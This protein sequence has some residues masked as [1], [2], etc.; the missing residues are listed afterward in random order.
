MTSVVRPFIRL[1]RA[2][3][4]RRSDSGSRAEVASSRIRIGGSL[5]SARAMAMRWRWP[6]ESRLPRS[7]ICGVVAAREVEDEVVG[8][9]GAGGGLDPR[10]VHVL[11]AVGDVGAH[12]VV[13][14]HRLLGDEADLLAQALERRVAHVD[15]VDGDGALG[16][17][18]E[19]RQ[20]LDERGLARARHA[21]DGHHLPGARG[22]GDPA[23]HGG[24]GVREAEGRRPCTRPRAACAGAGC[25]L[26]RSWISKWVSRTS[27]MRLLAASAPCRVAFMRDSRLIGV[28]MAK[29]A[30]RNEV[31]APVVRRP[32][33]MACAAVEER[34]D[35]GHAAHRLHE[36]GEDGGGARDPHV[37]VEQ[38]RRG[39]PEARG[40]EALHPER[41][42]HAEAGD[43][44][45]QDLRDV[46][47]AAQRR[48]VGGAQVAA[49]A[50][51]RDR[52]PAGMMKERAEGE[53]PVL[54]EQ[55]PQQ[56][57]DGQPFL[58]EVA[59]ELRHRGLDLLHVRRDV[60]HQRAVLWP[61]RNAKDWFRMW[62]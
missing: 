19:A 62:L 54:P 22:E 60:A 32:D 52:T 16:H 35:H 47:P 15:A 38:P 24:V 55:D 18:V 44:L 50:D 53:P 13:E 49:V 3:C 34:A 40:L 1:P 33:R 61:H 39:A 45:L 5:S 17:V 10:L 46:P 30:A 25:A 14:E 43:R 6:P 57:G 58:Q 56:A 9:G 20:Q 21:H 59:R 51:E 28:Y 7:P 11:E 31:K 27:K 29:S 2:C 23:Q 4:T 48:L 36:R 26:G 42:D 41:L 37:D 12:G 8:E